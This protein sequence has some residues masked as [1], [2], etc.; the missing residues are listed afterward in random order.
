ME[1]FAVSVLQFAVRLEAGILD[2]GQVGHLAVPGRNVVLAKLAEVIVPAGARV[3]GPEWSAP[4]CCRGRSGGLH[5]CRRQTL[6]ESMLHSHDLAGS[7]PASRPISSIKQGFGYEALY[8]RNQIEFH[9]PFL[10]IV[11]FIDHGILNAHLNFHGE[12][13]YVS[14][15]SHGDT[16]RDIP[17]I[18]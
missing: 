16:H 17:L 15:F 7:N 5:R 11:V 1:K 18:A 4:R 14:H 3:P 2:A 8:H 13:P 6:S 9:H 12:F 10:S